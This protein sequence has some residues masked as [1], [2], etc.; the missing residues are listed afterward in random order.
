M[1]TVRVD[2][3]L[4]PGVNAPITVDA[5]LSAA[6]PVLGQS[7]R[8][9]T[10]VRING[11]DEPAFR[12]PHVSARTLGE[13]DNVDVETRPVGALAEQALDDAVRYLPQIAASARAMA[14][15]LRGPRPADVRPALGNLA[16]NIALL[17]GLVHTA[18]LWA[19]Q[20]GLAATDWLGDDVAAVEQ[21]A[22]RLETAAAAEDW[23][24]AAAVLDADLPGALDGWCNR[25]TAGRDALLAMLAVPTA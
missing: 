14:V 10:A 23:S 25:L 13:A 1:L 12:E 7:G 6:E 2:S 5:L 11:V 3:S 19:R 9:V 20:A 22:G 8:I 16:D 17:A 4:I 24:A 15:D 18:D 21:A